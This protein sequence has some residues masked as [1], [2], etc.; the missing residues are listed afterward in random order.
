MNSITLTAPAKVNLFL[1]VLKK[2]KDGYHEIYTIFEKISL[3]DTITIFKIPRGIKVDSN[4]NITRSAKDN[5]AYK[6]AALVKREFGIDCGVEIYIK[7][8]IPIGAGLGGGSSD[9]ASV[10]I[11]MDRLFGL[12]MDKE[13]MINLAAKLGADV[14][15]FVSGAD[16]AVG[17]GAGEKLK[18]LKIGKKLWHLLIFPGIHSST[19]GVYKAFDRLDF[20]L[21]GHADDVRIHSSISGSTGFGDI[22][23]ML[24]NDLQCAAISEKKV[25]GSII[26]RLTASL[27]KKVV[28]SGS[29]SS[30]FCLYRTGK[31]AAK[32][33][34]RICR[35]IPARMRERWDIVI[36]KTENSKE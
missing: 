25:L 20:A 9:A 8:K 36:A 14:P 7:K 33:K 3:A 11:G 16:F 15:F 29:G 28:L 31:E 21:T 35:S 24:Y 6:A 30:V 17:E 1:R 2:R 23:A 5:I 26:K 32:A 10:I 13:H 19:K 22:E 18:T 34:A 27:G 12:Q 4:K